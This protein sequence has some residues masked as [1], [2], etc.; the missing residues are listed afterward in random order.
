MAVMVPSFVLSWQEEIPAEMTDDMIIIS[1]RQ[2]DN[3]LIV[4]P[5][6]TC[7]IGN[8]EFLAPYEMIKSSLLAKAVVVPNSLQRQKREERFLVQYWLAPPQLRRLLQEQAWVMRPHLLLLPA[9]SRTLGK[10]ETVSYQTECGQA[11]FF[12]NNINSG[13]ET[14]QAEQQERLALLVVRQAFQQT[15]KRRGRQ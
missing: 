10:A 14:T 4:S 11:I 15:P 3:R 1:P 13:Y 8:E 5:V 2:W 6:V 7:K 9:T 12:R